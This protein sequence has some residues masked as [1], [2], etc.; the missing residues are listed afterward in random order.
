[1]TFIPEPLI[2]YIRHCETKRYP[3]SLLYFLFTYCC[4]FK[5]PFKTRLISELD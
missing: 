4:I 2:D 3:N 1:L 5:L